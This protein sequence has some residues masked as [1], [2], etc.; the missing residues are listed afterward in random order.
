MFTIWFYW[1]F[2]NQVWASDPIT[3]QQEITQSSDLQ[4][5]IRQYQ[6]QN[7]SLAVQEFL[8]IITNQTYPLS[9]RLEAYIYLAEISYVDGNIAQAHTYFKA[10]LDKDPS[11]EIDY[12]RHPQD[13]CEHF[14]L[15]KASYSQNQNSNQSGKNFPISGYAPFGVYQFQRNH[16][17]K[18]LSYF[19]LELGTGVSSIV[20]FN[21]LWQNPQAQSGSEL[22]SKLNR[23]LIIQRGSTIAFY[24][25]WMFSVLDAQRDWHL[26]KNPNDAP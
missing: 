18:A 21:Y 14:G 13:I 4:E 9:V 2:A 1:L 16:H 23:T 15:Y 22:E 12:E 19:A 20:L 6:L 3:A 7:R 5:G 26:Q 8:N 10:V 17:Y 25:I 11:Y 24:S